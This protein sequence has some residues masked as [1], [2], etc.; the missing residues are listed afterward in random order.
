MKKTLLLR[1]IFVLT[2]T[3]CSGC[4]WLAVNFTPKPVVD[5]VAR[6][7]AVA[8]I[9]VEHPPSTPEELKAY[10]EVNKELFDELAIFYGL[11]RGS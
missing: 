2:I 4:S 5:A 9:A 1:I 7:S 10:L 3:T 6:G 8:N 11:K